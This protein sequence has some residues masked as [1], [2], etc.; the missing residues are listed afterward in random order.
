MIFIG[1]KLKNKDN[2]GVKKVI[3][4]KIF[5]GTYY[6]KAFTG[7]VI[8]VS[9]KKAKY[10][11]KL[12]RKI[13]M[14]K[15][16]QKCLIITSKFNTKRLNSFYLKFDENRSILVDDQKKLLASKILSPAAKEILKNYKKYPN[17]KK[18]IVKSKIVF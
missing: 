7:A 11:Q 9:I 15:K 13:K 17:L 4:I 8:K 3:C 2:S 12:K 14:D 10:N 16:T 5:G 1:T 18:I 6:Q